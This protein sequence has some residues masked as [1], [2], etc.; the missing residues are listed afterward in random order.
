MGF[1]NSR[2]SSSV[3]RTYWYD[4]PQVP[5]LF[6]YLNLQFIFFGL[7][8][9]VVAVAVSVFFQIHEP[10]PLPEIPFFCSFVQLACF[11]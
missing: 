11:I 10:P 7:K 2:N 9:V 8:D 6:Q 3:G 4:F 5:R 1:T